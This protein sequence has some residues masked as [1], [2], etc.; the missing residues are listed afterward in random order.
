MD[1]ERGGP[2]TK[3]RNGIFLEAS[4]YDVLPPAIN[5]IALILMQLVR[6]GDFQMVITCGPVED[7]TRNLQVQS[8][9]FERLSV[10]EDELGH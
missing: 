8:T 2:K 1:A 7:G 10:R 6:A 3:P 9:V 5:E 4:D